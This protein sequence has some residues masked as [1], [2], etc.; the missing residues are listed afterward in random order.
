[1]SYPIPTTD[2]IKSIYTGI[3]ALPGLAVDITGWN[4]TGPIFAEVINRIRPTVEIEVGSWKGA[5]AIHAANLTR[6]LGLDTR[7][8][9][10]DLWV[11]PIGVGLGE[12]PR[13]HIPERFD[14]PTFYHQFLFN[15]AHA[16]CDD[17]IIPVR[18][19]TVPIAACLGAWGV[20]ADMIYIDAL[21]TEEGC[22]ADIAAYWPLLRKGGVMLGDDFSS[23]VGVRR[24]VQRF[25]AQVGRAIREMP[26]AE[27]T[28]WLLDPK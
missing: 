7:I 22:Y 6:A 10:V 4:S 15:V 13:T 11:P 27:G 14:A 16:K 23:H 26:A 5:S 12:F 28:Q 17:R 20:V 9:C 24:A 2:E 1:M 3:E 25:S 8:Y 18:G 19:L 21:H